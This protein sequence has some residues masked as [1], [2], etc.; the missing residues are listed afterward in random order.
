MGLAI[1]LLFVGMAFIMLTLFFQKRRMDATD[2]INAIYSESIWKRLEKKDLSDEE[3]Q[4]SVSALWEELGELKSS[5]I[6]SRKIGKNKES[7]E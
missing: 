4:K 2:K 6:A 1:A 7:K 3:I 5:F